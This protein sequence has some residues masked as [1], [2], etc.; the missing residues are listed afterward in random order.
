MVIP[1]LTI[2]RVDDAVPL[3]RALVAGGVRT[4]E[5]TLRTPV[6]VEAAK[7]IIA[8]VPDA[9][10]GIGTILNAD[11]LARAQALGAKFGISPGADAG[12]P[13]SRCRERSA[14]RAGHRHRVRIDAGARRMASTSVKFFPAEQAGGI[15][16]LRALAGP[17]P[18]RPLLPDR[19]H[20]RGQRGDVA[21]RTECAVRRRLL[22]VPA[23]DIRAGNWAGISAM[24]NS[25]MKS[26]KPA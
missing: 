16:A 20:R 7:A 10:V 12:T 19:R 24:C 15:K 5:V 21:G 17:F 9:I 1:V 4:L 25:A 26:L 14:V 23:A 3:A 18:Q 6:A 11:D 22:A 8:E 2:E 13:E